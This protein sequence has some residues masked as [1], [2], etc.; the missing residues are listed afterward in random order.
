MIYP[1]KIKTKLENLPWNVWFWLF[2]TVIEKSTK[3]FYNKYT[4]LAEKNDLVLVNKN[5]WKIISS[6][7]QFYNK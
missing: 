5:D 2:E 4:L 6:L 7:K 3:K 1:Y